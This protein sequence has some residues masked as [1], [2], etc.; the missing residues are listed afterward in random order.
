[1]AKELPYF[2]FTVQDWQN[3]KISIE[4]FEMQGLFISV[5]GYYWIND[6]DL[7]LAM[8]KKKFSIATNLLD[9]LITLGILKHEN[10][11]DKVEIV[12]LNEQYD[13]LSEKRKARQNAGSKGGNAKAKLKQKGSY[14]DKDNNKDNNKDKDNKPT[15]EEFLNHAVSVKPN[16]DQE[17]VKLKFQ[18]WV[19]NE[20]RTGKDK[21]IKNWKS[22]LT[23]TLQFIADQKT[24]GQKRWVELYATSGGTGKTP[25]LLNDQE[26]IEKKAS[27]FWKEA[28]EL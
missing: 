12:F 16:V 24:G 21:P 3:G 7:T 15:M 18:S 26:L 22:T 13:L 14:K 20:W 8:L 6:C 23:N 2:R 17:A 10:R 9:E 25:F 28:S 11:H 5:C 4:S 19:Q 1:M 27:G